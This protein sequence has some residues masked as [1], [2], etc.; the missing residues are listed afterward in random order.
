MPE[1]LEILR[2]VFGYERFLPMQ[3]LV[4]SHVLAGK[5]ALVLMPTGGGKS[6]C[7]QVPALCME[8]LTLVVSP[9]VSLQRDQVLALRAN[10]VSAAV[11][12]STLSPEESEAVLSDIA[13]SKLK[14]LYISPERLFSGSTPHLLTRW[15]V[16]L[17]AID[18]SHCISFWGHDFRP[19]Y[20]QLGRLRVLLP[21]VPLIA[22]TATADPAIQR[23][24]L[25]Q[26]SIDEASVF[27]SSFNRPNLRLAVQS[28]QKKLERLL[29]IGRAHV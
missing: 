27:K 19:E 4:I 26:L 24:I 29:E 18:E 9:L 15:K 5:D 16:G 21:R 8:G 23:D 17:V 1:P 28:G 25:S 6:L 10:G 13:H 11:L 3:E 22:L 14:L 7:F 20:T 12:N 2:R